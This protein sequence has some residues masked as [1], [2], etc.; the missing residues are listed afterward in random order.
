MSGIGVSDAHLAQLEAE[1]PGLTAALKQADKRE[2]SSEE[3]TRQIL[4]SM[5]HTPI[6]LDGLDGLGEDLGKLVKDFMDGKAAGEVSK[7]FK[8]PMCSMDQRFEKMVVS[9]VSFADEKVVVLERDGTPVKVRGHSL[10]LIYMLL[11]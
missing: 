7:G 3:C 9:E 1:L 11:S 8:L 10:Y 2:I 4:K 5:K 6:F